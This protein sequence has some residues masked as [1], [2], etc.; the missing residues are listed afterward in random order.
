MFRDLDDP[1]VAEY[2]RGGQVSSS[3][4]VVN[5][6]SALGISTAW[7]CTL[8]LAGICGNFPAEVMERVDETTRRPAVNHPLRKVMT[9]RP[10]GWQTP[11]E[12]R[13]ML[14]A[15]AVNKGDG[16]ALK[17][18]SMG[19]VIALWPLDDPDRMEVAQND[20]MSLSYTFTTRKGRKV[21]LRQEDLLHL[22]GFSVDGV[23]GIG[24]L[25]S[26]REAMGLS[27]TQQTAG[28]RMFKNGVLG[29]GALKT[30]GTLS[31]EAYDRLKADL[32]TNNVGAENA[33]KLMILEDG[34]DYASG[35]MSAVDMQF[36]EGRKFSRTDIAMFYGVPPFL[37]GD[38]EK[39][40]SWGTGLEQQNTGFIQYTGLDLHVMWEQACERDLLTDADRKAGIYI[41]IDSRVLLRG[42]SK[43][44]T[45]NYSR[46]L[47]SGG[48]QPWMTVNEVRALEDLPPIEGGNVLP[49]RMGAAPSPGK[50][51]AE[52]KEPDDD[53]A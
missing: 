44:R 19:R 52:P 49:A 12:F 32:D 20:D 4:A 51:P 48:G 26:A 7:R 14:T 50:T 40:T 15:H 18:T 13:K 1:A 39:A 53:E 38:T 17:I 23:R 37:L 34:L 16:F 9:E 33:G 22:R 6:G 25:R 42:D 43:T 24:V 30:A 2:L 10:N 11:A 27:M 36:L 47:G 41:K 21:P 46:A 5:M 8:L 45:E 3:G 31:D 28:G 35:L 29:G